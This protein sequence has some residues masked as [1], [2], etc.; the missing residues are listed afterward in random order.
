MLLSAS[1]RFI[2][3]VSVAHIFQDTLYAHKKE[4]RFQNVRNGSVYLSKSLAAWHT[5]HVTPQVCALHRCEELQRG[6][7]ESVLS[8]SWLICLWAAL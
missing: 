6:L 3:R 5:F 2:S 8:L 4:Q 1:H 7:R